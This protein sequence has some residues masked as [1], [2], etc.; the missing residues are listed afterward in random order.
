MQYPPGIKGLYQGCTP[1]MPRLFIRAGHT[2]DIP[3]L[4]AD[5]TRDIS[6]SCTKK[7][8]QWLGIDTGI[9]LHFLRT[10]LM[11]FLLKLEEYV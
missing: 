7:T 1:G 6:M 5:H 11:G 2:R 4:Y 3:G 9:A 8:L 10:G